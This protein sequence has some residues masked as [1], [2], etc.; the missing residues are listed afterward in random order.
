MNNDVATLQVIA[1]T[2]KEEPMASQRV[3]AENAGMSI[4]LMNAV[5]KRFVERG[6]LMLTNVNLRKLCYAITPQGIAELSHRSQSFARRTFALANQYN[7]QL[8]ALVAQ[9]KSSGKACVILYGQS[10]I[11]FLLEYACQSQEVAFEEQPANAQPDKKA[12]CIAGELCQEEEI[13][14]LKKS[15]CVSLL[16]LLDEQE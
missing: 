16:E 5:I 11:K 2:L 1:D 8:C 15:G 9:A 13:A 12:F 6:W 3:L 4:G 7:E 14:R 10:Y